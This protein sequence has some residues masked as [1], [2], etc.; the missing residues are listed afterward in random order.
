MTGIA[1][2]AP[3]S[4]KMFGMGIKISVVVLTGHVGFITM[5]TEAKLLIRHPGIVTVNRGVIGLSGK[6]MK[7]G[8][9][10]RPRTA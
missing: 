7:P 9:A 5:A 1:G 8:R 2:Y 4:I 6:E 3:V 10:V